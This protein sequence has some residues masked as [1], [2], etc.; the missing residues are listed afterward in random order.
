VL[1]IEEQLQQA[2]WSGRIGFHPLLQSVTGGES[3]VLEK[4]RDRMNGYS[5]F[6]LGMLMLDIAKLAMQKEQ[7]IHLDP[8]QA[9][10]LGPFSD[11]DGKFVKLIEELVSTKLVVKKNFEFIRFQV[12]K[13]RQWQG[14]K[15][16]RVA[17]MHF[18]L[19][20]AL[21][22]DGK[23]TVILGHSLRQKDVK[24]LR[25]IYEFL[26][27][28]IRTPN[29]YEIGSDS[30]IAPSIESLMAIYGVYAEAQNKAVTILEPVIASSTALY[31]VDD[32]RDDLAHVEKY[33]PEI[34][35]IPLLEGN[36]PA[37]RIET[38]HAPQRITETPIAQAV[39]VASPEAAPMI[40]ASMPMAQSA[41]HGVQPVQHTDAVPAP[42]F[43]L[44]MKSPV[45]TNDT[46]THQIS[47]EVAGSV[48]G[49]GLNYMRPGPTP[50][51][52]PPTPPVGSLLE[53]QQPPQQQRVGVFGTPMGGQ[54]L[55]G[56]QAMPAQA[57]AMKVPETARLFN[58]QLYIPVESSGV[59]GIPQNAVLIDNKVHVPM[60]AGVAGAVAP[61]VGGFAPAAGRFGQPAQITDPSQ[62]PGLNEQEIM[63]Y[64]SNPVMFQNL[65]Q[66]M[67][68][69]S[70]M[71][72]TGVM[73]Q[74]Q[75]QVPR[76]L[77]NAVQ[78]AQQQQTMNQ[79]FFGRR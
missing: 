69:G 24:M 3:R 11:A 19:Y 30:K 65:L 33:L 67:Q 71:A 7:H 29:F 18:P 36:S 10:Y 51:A 32:W 61:A 75:Q 59:S 77:Q 16:M 27:P 74:R 31:I 46:A 73:A 8:A 42:R 78:A 76:Y 37:N 43:K 25:A 9:A 68:A 79:G 52:P 45:V 20:D 14:Q 72:A 60:V 12:I 21:P 53:A 40:P 66:Q 47:N 70:A 56:Q 55:P 57:Q 64:R 41:T 44:G 50:T 39:R 22:T 38:A 26:F 6:M 48:Q 34:R 1:P 49:G 58:G 63:Y 15:R 2:D 62:V 54:V 28:D 5:N 17:V 35:K 4:F 23:G 13:G